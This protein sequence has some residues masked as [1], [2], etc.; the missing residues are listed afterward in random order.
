MATKVKFT[1]TFIQKLELPE[2][3][4][5]EFYQDT[6]EPNLY[7]KVTSA[8]KVLLMRF[9][10]L[11][12]QYDRNLSEQRN[13][14]QARIEVGERKVEI[15]NG[16]ERLEALKV[17]QAAEKEEAERLEAEAVKEAA[18]KQSVKDCIT[19]Y[20]K[21]SKGLKPRTVSDYEGLRDNELAPYASMP[22]ND[23][24]RQK[25]I[26]ML[27]EIAGK[28]QKANPDKKGSR[29][30]QALRLIR[31]TC[32]HHELGCQNWGR[33]RGKSFPWIA[34]K[35]KPTDLDPE[36]GHGRMIWAA[37]SRRN[38]PGVSFLKALLLT[39]A[40]PGTSPEA[41]DGEMLFLKAGDVD[42]AKG[43]LWF[44]DTKNGTDHRVY[45]S[46]ALHEVLEPLVKGKA[47]D[48][49]VFPITADP[50]KLRYAVSKEIGVYFTCHD[51]RKFFGNNCMSLGIPAGIYKRCL[52]HS[53]SSLDVTHAHYAMATPS[54]MRNA[55]QRHADSIVG[56][57]SA[58]I[59]N[60]PSRNAA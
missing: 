23:V 2:A 6:Q 43:E 58:T 39:G 7:L 37:L 59:I 16:N 19:S 44:R 56:E 55:W 36:A 49:R 42:L 52:N 26:D 21:D 45:I 60:L 17:K 28:I 48:E 5:R 51:L 22:L 38:T 34:T 30:N 3:G 25:A 14:Y 15:R 54:Q 32:N 1:D 18:V 35:A 4:K 24:T 47:K 10:F 20:I 29:A 46:P 12:I 13:V 27:Y 8:G 41:E 11:G 57:S 31:A 9:K 50:K 33:V 53:V 40:R